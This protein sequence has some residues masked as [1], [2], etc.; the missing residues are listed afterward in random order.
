MD[1]SKVATYQI[2]LVQAQAYRYLQAHFQAALKPFDLTIPEWSLLGLLYDH[3]EMTLTQITAALKSKASHPT[4]LVDRLEERDL[5]H[6]S[7][8]KNDKRTKLVALTPKG[9]ALVPEIENIA[10][11]HIGQAVGHVDRKLLENYFQVLQLLAVGRATEV[12]F[13]DERP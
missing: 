8:H 7:V 1:I 12:V 9:K 11:A 10:R 5:V 2:G 6:R 13:K 3:N 4:V